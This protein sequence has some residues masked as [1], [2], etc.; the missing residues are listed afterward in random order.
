[1]ASLSLKFEIYATNH[2]CGEKNSMRVWEL[3]VNQPQKPQEYFP[4]STH[5]CIDVTCNDK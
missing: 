4:G 2:V 1:M 3:F 5:K